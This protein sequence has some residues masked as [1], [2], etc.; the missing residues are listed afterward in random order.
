MD[1]FLNLPSLSIRFAIVVALIA[2]IFV[3]RIMTLGRLLTVDEPLW[4]GRAEQFIKGV[5]TGHFERTL[6]AGQP[7]VTTAWLAGVVDRWHS[8]AASQA[9]IAVACGL[10]VLLCTYFLVLLWGSQWGVLAGFVIGLQPLL[11]GHSRVVHTDALLALFSLAAALAL[12]VALVP[13]RERQPVSTRYLIYSGI[14]TA[15]A[16]LTKMFAVFLLPTA[17]VLMVVHSWR[18]RQTAALT[19]RHL[20]LWGTAIILALFIFW[21]ALWLQSDRVAALLFERGS[22]H[23]EGTR[24]E[25]TTSLSWYYLREIPF[26]LSTTG[27]LLVPFGVLGL[28]LL[29]QRGPMRWSMGW[30]LVV[31]GAL[32]ALMSLGADKSDRYVLFCIVVIELL[33]V[34][35]LAWLYQILPSHFRQRVVGSL[36]IM[37]VAWLALDASRLHPYYLAHYNR[38]YPIESTHKLGWGEG[39]ETAADWI[40]AQDPNAK[41]GAYYSRVFDYFY[42]GEVVPISHYREANPD[43]VV[44]YRS[45]FER[46]PDSMETDIINNFLLTGKTPAHV[47]TINGLPYA[48]IFKF[49]QAQ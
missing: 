19:M 25:E 6:V 13:L 38:L 11:L 35:G 5:A 7:G 14:L 43:Y 22:L 17:V 42:P 44:L 41:V 32:L 16:I 39:L 40:R 12:L 24:E 30:L 15:L 31:A 34:V 48:W 47:V 26:R 28:G 23:A 4:Q 33:S 46:G 3:P 20:G 45:M 18:Y 9:A 2:A 36:A 1:R 49:E 8:L 29:R 27:S 21:P 37:L 10:L